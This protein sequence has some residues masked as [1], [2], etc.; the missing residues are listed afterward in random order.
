MKVTVIC[1]RPLGYQALYS[2]Q[3]K[4]KYCLRALIKHE[5][6]HICWGT[7]QGCHGPELETLAF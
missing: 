5:L 1:N 2:S 4:A 7:R 6:V 3:S